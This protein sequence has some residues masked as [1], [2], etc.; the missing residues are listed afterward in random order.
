MKLLKISDLARNPKR[1]KEKPLPL[2]YWHIVHVK[3][4]LLEIKNMI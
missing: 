3:R 4:K 1:V 2:L